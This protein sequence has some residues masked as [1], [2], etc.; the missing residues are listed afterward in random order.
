M[1]SNH[2]MPFGAEVREDGS[3]RFRLWAPQARR[4]ELRLED[5]GERL[6]LDRLEKGWFELLT[7]AAAPGS[8]YRFRIDDRSNVPDPASRF[9]PCDVDGPSQVIDPQEFEWNDAEWRGRPWE[10][11]VIYELHVGAFTQEGTFRAV[12][13]KLD[14]LSALGATALELMPVADFPGQRNWGYDGVLLYA[15]DSAYGPPAD[16]KQLTQAAHTRGMMVF[17][18]VVYNHFG[19]YG[20]YL[21]VYSPQFFTGRHRTPWGEAINF[22]DRESRTIRDFFIHNALY[23]LEEYHFD[24]L[25]LDAVHAMIDDSTPDIL[26][27][28]A[29]CVREKFQGERRIHLM[30]ENGNNAAQFLRRDQGNRLQFYDAQWN[31]DIHHALHV[32]ITSESDGYY[33]DYVHQPIQQLGRCLAEGFAY[34]GEYS[35]YHGTKRGTPSGTLPPSAFISFL[36]NHDQVGNRAFGERILQLARPEAVRAAMEI[37]L[38]APAPPLLFMGEEFGAT[39]PFLFF[40]DF[41]GDLALS[42]T[43]GRRKEFT[44]FSQFSSIEKRDRIPDPNAEE[45]F[46]RSKLNWSILANESNSSCLQL[47]RKLL[48]TRRRVVAPCLVGVASVR[49]RYCMLQNLGLAVDWILGDGSVLKLYANLGGDWLTTTMSPGAGQF[50]SSS[51]EAAKALEHNRLAPWSVIWLLQTCDPG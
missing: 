38:L 2:A 14:Y 15:P 32:L 4:V 50:Y 18:D 23:W 3:V 51:P 29:R 31:D 49:T 33:S 27:E 40:C 12:E 48:S 44:R 9:Q 22:D 24:G 6:L 19:P 16:L 46:R 34:Q 17:L 43:T 45:S 26:T 28:L 35:Q 1:R 39:S 11:A 8:R 20:N 41:Q 7:R 13:Q 5:T 42:V 47:Y 25:R 21:R 10:E 30:L 37:L 36:Q